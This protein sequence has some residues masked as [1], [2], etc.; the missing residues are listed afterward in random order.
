M[1]ELSKV[2]DELALGAPIGRAD[3]HDVV[4]RSR[5]MG[6]GR[7]RTPMLLAAALLML[8]GLVGTAV[9]VG[10]NLLAQQERFHAQAPDHPER[11]G[12]VVQ[13]TSGD[14]WALIAWRSKVGLCLDFAVPDNSPFSCG[15][16]V[17][18][19]GAPSPGMEPPVHT[20]AG[21]V[22]GSNL[23]GVS[24]GKTTVFGAAASDV[25]AV[26][27]ELIDGRLV[28]TQIFDAPPELVVDVKL[29][30]VRL[31]LGALDHTAGHDAWY[32]ARGLRAYDA[33]GRLMERVEF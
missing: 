9:G 8:L 23:V 10:V 4:A 29:F 15:F 2:L 19:A 17:R 30:I 18:G 12:S 11:I 5:G 28:E 14:G 32:G 7:V 21:F 27:V 3:W 31:S 1:T 24:D 13:I 22:S 26:K 16:P 33:D 25:A 20:V 6:R